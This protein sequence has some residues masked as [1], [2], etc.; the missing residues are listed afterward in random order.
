MLLHCFR[1]AF[2]VRVPR[3]PELLMSTQTYNQILSS[4]CS[5]QTLLSPSQIT[6]AVFRGLLHATS[7][8]DISPA[9]LYPVQHYGVILH[10]FHRVGS[11][12][13]LPLI[14]CWAVIT[15]SN[16]DRYFK[17]NRENWKKENW[18]RF[19]FFLNILL[20]IF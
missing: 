10:Q 19:L 2:S 11:E 16:N 3:H 20:S 6:P 18:Q 1:A 5:T 9:V 4:C 13:V 12:G 17:E 15:T 7:D 14:G 8:E